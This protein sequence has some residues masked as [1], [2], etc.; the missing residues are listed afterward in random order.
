MKKKCTLSAERQTMLAGYVEYLCEKQ[1]HYD[2]RAKHME[3]VLLFLHKAES[4]NRKG[5]RH[6]AKDNA[7]IIA[8]CPWTAAA[9]C[10]FLSLNGMGR[11]NLGKNRERIIDRIDKRNE[12]Q[13]R[14]VSDF[15]NWL[16]SSR[17]Y[18][19]STIKIYT[20]SLRDY[21]SYFDTFGQENVRQYINQVENDGKSPKT[22]RIR[23]TCLE[24]F[25]EYLKKP[26]K[27][28]RPKIQMSL[29]TENIPSEIEYKRMLDWAEK[30]KP[31]TAFIIK[32]MATTGCR[33]SELVQFTYE[34]ILQGTAILK[35]KGS[36]YRRFFF[37]KEL[38][39]ESA[40]KTGYV[41]I[42]KKGRPLSTRGVNY[43]LRQAARFSGVEESKAHAHAFRHFFAKKFLKKTK[44]VVG[45]A[46]LLGHG[47]VDTTRIYLQKS[48]EEQRNDIDKIVDW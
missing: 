39:K 4:V 2:T 5:W 28:R 46:E 47:S 48:L 30:N 35:G 21:F 11:K 41:C 17:D 9:V 38:Q 10:A 31:S 27:I 14:L 37:T 24:K 22:I 33:V 34:M 18:S 19:E 25:G 1:M 12:R 43:K 8:R 16:M 20:S 6:Y 45:L 3:A 36:K 42:N 32:A 40:G 44:D 15:V 29:S 7:E 26:V 23:I 13:E